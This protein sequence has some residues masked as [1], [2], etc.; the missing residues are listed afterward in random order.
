MD[1]I[2]QELIDAIIDNVPQSSLPS[3]SLV[4]KR[5]QRKSQKRVLGTI[6]FSSEHE[7]KRWCTD[8]PQDSDGISSYVRHVTIKRIHS[9]TEPGLFSRLLR[10]LSSLKALSMYR[11][12]FPDEFPGHISRGEFGKGITTLHLRFLY[13]RLPTL[14]SAILSLPDLKELRVEQCK[15]KPGGSLPTYSITPE[16][17][18]LESLELLGRVDGIGEALA[19]FRFTSRRLSLDVGT[20]NVEQLLLL[21]SKTVVKLRLCGAWS[22]WILRPSGGD[23]VRYSRYSSCQAS[24]CPPTTVSRSHHSSHRPLFVSPLASPYKHHVFHQLSSSID[25]HRCRTPPLDYKPP[26]WGLVGRRGSVAV[27]DR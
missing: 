3:C 13:Y 26:F 12:E 17:G 24:H 4:A 10:S 11:I 18:P 27:T 8:I 2:P 15:A 14:T 21:S 22:L 1:S 7:V 25:I 9:W 20:P 6:A 16:R 19:K 23:N 5:W